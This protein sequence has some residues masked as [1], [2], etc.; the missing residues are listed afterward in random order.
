MHSWWSKVSRSRRLSSAT[1]AIP[2]CFW[3]ETVFDRHEEVG[4][5]LPDL[6]SKCI[7]QNSRFRMDIWTMWGPSHTITTHEKTQNFSSYSNLMILEP[8]KN[9]LSDFP[10]NRGFEGIWGKFRISLFWAAIRFRI[11]IPTTW[12]PPHTTIFHKQN[13]DRN[14]KLKSGDPGAS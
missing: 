12:N 8:P 13:Y 1:L 2:H 9:L 6:R 10:Q 4:G 7:P 3:M 14:S 5:N 11:R